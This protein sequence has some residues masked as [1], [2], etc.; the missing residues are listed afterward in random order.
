MGKKRRT[1][2]T[3]IFFFIFVFCFGITIS[4]LLYVHLD[5]QIEELGAII[6]SRISQGE[7]QHYNFKKYIYG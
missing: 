5:E 2:K 6:I 4:L 1:F 7:I 3:V